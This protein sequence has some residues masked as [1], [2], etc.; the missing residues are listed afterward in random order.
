M[1]IGTSRIFLCKWTGRV[2]ITK[3]NWFREGETESGIG[4]KFVDNFTTLMNPGTVTDLNWNGRSFMCVAE[5]TNEMTA[6]ISFT[7]SVKG[8]YTKIMGIYFR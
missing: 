3:L 6:T 7:L 4:T 1:Y 2:H 8:N 5:T